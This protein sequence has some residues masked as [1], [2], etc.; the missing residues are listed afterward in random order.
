MIISTIA[1]RELVHLP[2]VIAIGWAESDVYGESGYAGR[3]VVCQQRYLKTETERSVA[4]QWPRRQKQRGEQAIE[5][6]I[7]LGRLLSLQSSAKVTRSTTANP[8][9]VI[10]SWGIT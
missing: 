6:L 7:E 4:A 2:V 9:P 5:E 3:N 8:K 1:E 10:P